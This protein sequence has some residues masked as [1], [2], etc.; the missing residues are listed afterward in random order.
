MLDFWDKRVLELVDMELGEYSIF[1]WL[2]NCG[3]DFV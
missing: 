3:D 2:K 1:C